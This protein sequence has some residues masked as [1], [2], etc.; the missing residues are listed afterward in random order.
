MSKSFNSVDNSGYNKIYKASLLC[1]WDQFIIGFGF[2]WK[3]IEHHHTYPLT[4]NV[5][6]IKRIISITFV[7]VIWVILERADKLP[8][9]SFALEELLLSLNATHKEDEGVTHSCKTW[10]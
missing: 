1:Q 3:I 5:A 4:K 7:M 8:I 6:D 2:L 10:W 9:L